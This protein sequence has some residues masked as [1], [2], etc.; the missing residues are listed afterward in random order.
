[1]LVLLWASPGDQVPR[2]PPLRERQ[3]QGRQ[4]RGMGRQGS[5]GI[6]VPVKQ[7]QM[8]KTTPEVPRTLGR[9]KGRGEWVGGGRSPGGPGGK[10]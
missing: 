9:G 8:G 6:R 2:T 5:R 4:G 10:A 7:A 1:M 3:T